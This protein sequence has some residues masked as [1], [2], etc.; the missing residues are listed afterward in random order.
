MS[1][2]HG[3]TDAALTRLC[4]FRLRCWRARGGWSGGW[5]GDSAS[6][7]SRIST[8]CLGRCW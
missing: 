1:L 7:G 8:R 2:G 3:R 4:I 5:P 6:P